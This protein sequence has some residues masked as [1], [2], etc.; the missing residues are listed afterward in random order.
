MCWEERHLLNCASLFNCQCL[1]LCAL[2]KSQCH[3]NAS[4]LL[5]SVDGERFWKVWKRE[6]S[7][8]LSSVQWFWQASKMLALLANF[9]DGADRWLS[10]RKRSNG[11]VTKNCCMLHGSCQIGLSSAFCFTSLGN[12]PRVPDLLPLLMKSHTSANAITGKHKND[13]N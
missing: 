10:K 5:F 8:F 1:R 4:N 6:I 3:A 7:R 11:W 13:K 12:R 2:R 9:N